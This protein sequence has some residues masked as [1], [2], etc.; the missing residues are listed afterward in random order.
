M[1]PQLHAAYDDGDERSEHTLSYWLLD[2][3]P[4]SR[5]NGG[6]LDRLLH[7]LDHISKDTK[8]T[9]DSQY[10]ISLVVSV[11]KVILKFGSSHAFTNC[12]FK[13]EMSQVGVIVSA[14]LSAQSGWFVPEKEVEEIKFP[15]NKKK[16]KLEKD[17]GNAVHF[18]STLSVY[19]LNTKHNHMECF[20]ESYPC[21]GHLAYKTFLRKTLVSCG[22][23]SIS[24]Y[25]FSLFVTYGIQPI[26]SH[27]NAY[28][29]PQL[30]L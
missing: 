22:D 15:L 6:A 24:K 9:K 29:Q 23:D 12:L 14:L 1:Q 17:E 3:D 19:Y 10:S 21:F 28:L 5:I 20:I 7:H 26:L 16:I 11:G 2:D 8:V 30:S 25:T 18:R 27:H 4:H 13:A